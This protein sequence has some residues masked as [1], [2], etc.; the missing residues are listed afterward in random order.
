MKLLYAT[1][2][3][4]PSP[5]ANRIQI[6][7]M[8]EIFNQR[9]GKDFYLGIG[10]SKSEKEFD[11]Q[12]VIMESDL[13]SFFLAKAYL[14]YIKKNK[15]THVFC[16][17]EKLLFFMIIFNWWFRTGVKFCYEI[18]YL[19]Y[20]TKLWYRVILNKSDFII[21]ITE[22]MKNVLV[23]K[24]KCLAKK[25]LV[26]PDAVDFDKF[27]LDLTVEEARLKT[28]LQVERKIIM[29][30]GSVFSWKGIDILYQSAKE[31]SNDYLFV[32]IGGRDS[33]V[34][35]FQ[36]VH[37]ETDNFKML[38]HKEHQEI[39]VYL[40]AADVLVLPNSDREEVSR[41]CTSPMKLF[42]YMAAGRPI[43]ASDLPSI[44]EV[45]DEDSSVLVEPSDSLDLA[46]GIKLVLSNQKLAES[47]ANQSF[48]KSR[49]YS[50]KARVDKIINFINNDLA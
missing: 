41:I 44:R 25:I 9:L 19:E 10:Q 21:S 14:R 50:W 23:N 27:N 28:G 43:V 22:G 40:K 30:T 24:N 34:K 46:R 42:E 12:M 15:F 36:V 13:R 48:K 20:L 8:A 37:P 45:L 5:L 16:R 17:E 11:G 31:F 3:T 18:H 7:S 38:G 6:L 39:P 47:I 1:S 26:A 29:Y 33:W 2:I 32:I 35:E 4:L 49:T